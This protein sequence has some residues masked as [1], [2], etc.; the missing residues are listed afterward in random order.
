MRYLIQTEPRSGLVVPAQDYGYTVVD[1]V[2]QHNWL[3][4][5][6]KQTIRYRRNS[7]FEKD[8]LS[9]SCLPVGSV[10]FCLDWYRQAGCGLVKPLN[11]PKE[12][13]TSVR[14]KVF[15]AAS[16]AEDGK[17]YYGKDIN[18]IKAHWNGVYKSYSGPKTLQFSEWTNDVVSE[19]RLFVSRK[20]IVD[21]RCYLGDQWR[22]PDRL[23]CECVAQEY[24][25]YNPAFTLDVFV[26][27]NGDTDILELH[28]FFACGLYGFDDARLLLRM[29]RDSR[30]HI[31]KR[32]T[33][34][35]KSPTLQI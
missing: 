28:D 4:P 23:Y 15:E 14:R 30:Q 26:R 8:E 35:M 33:V 9:S 34:G 1:A 27:Q 29:L 24:G 20:E 6:D 22:L 10:E 18:A 32:Y 21:I 17:Q 11:I 25:K 31:M 13:W 7:Q 2:E 12:L 16:L 19:W 5:D 3:Y